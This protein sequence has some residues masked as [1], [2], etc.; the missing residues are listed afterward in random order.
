LLL[1]VADG[2]GHG[3]GAAEAAGTTVRTFRDHPG[4]APQEGLQVIHDALRS[5]RGAA[6]AIA[7]IDSG[8]RLVR[9]C[10]VGNVAGAVLSEGGSRNMVSHH[11]TVGL[12]VRKV[13]EFTYPWPDRALLVMHS[14]GLGSRWSLDP[15]PGLRQKHPGLVAGV[16][17]RD[18]GRGR[19]DATVVVVREA[20]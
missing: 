12:G 9:F 20:A 5:T 16:L 8:R 19:D 3:P 13:Q 11:G 2:L 4:L 10:G 7:E 15:Y 14:D 17:Y 1:L 18:F 6:V